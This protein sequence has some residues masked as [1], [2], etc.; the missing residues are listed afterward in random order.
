MILSFESMPARSS[1]ANDF[2]CGAMQFKFWASCVGGR[3]FLM[4]IILLES[5]L[6]NLF[7]SRPVLSVL[8][9][10]QKLRSSFC[11]SSRDV[12]MRWVEIIAENRI[13]EAI[14]SGDFAKLP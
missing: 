13:Q 5:P 3:R 10:W 1:A 11:I 14:E 7:C 2:I 9:S 12:A 8:Q 4:P 6:G